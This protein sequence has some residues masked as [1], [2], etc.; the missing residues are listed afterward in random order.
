VHGRYEEVCWEQ[1]FDGK[2]L[3][4]ASSHLKCIVGCVV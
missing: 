3:E 2:P 4:N 1:R